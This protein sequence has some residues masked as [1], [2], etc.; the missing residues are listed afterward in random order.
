LDLRTVGGL[1][2]IGVVLLQMENRLLFE[3]GLDIFMGLFDGEARMEYFMQVSSFLEQVWKAANPGQSVDRTIIHF[4]FRGLTRKSTLKPTLRL[5]GMFYRVLSSKLSVNNLLLVNILLARHL[6]VIENPDTAEEAFKAIKLIGKIISSLP[7][8]DL[9]Y[10]FYLHVFL[11]EFMILDVNEDVATITATFKKFSQKGLLSKF[12]E[13]FYREFVAVY[14]EEEDY[15][16]CLSILQSF[17]EANQEGLRN[18]AIRVLG[19]FAQ[20]VTEVSLQVV[21]DCLFICCL[22][23]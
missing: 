11:L 15:L 7:N 4:L 18:A 19:S 10:I 12:L 22:L 14:P 1:A 2:G 16:C 6:I 5:L 17:M 20:Y 21:L 8:L 13:Q 3:L 23:L 9:R